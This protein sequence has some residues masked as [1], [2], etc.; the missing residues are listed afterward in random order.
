[1]TIAEVTKKCGLTA[2]TFKVLRAQWIADY[3]RRTTGGIRGYS[4]EYCRWVE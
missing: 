4:I 2:D 1:M 3:V